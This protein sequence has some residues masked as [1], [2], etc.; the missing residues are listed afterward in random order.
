MLV[1][2][3]PTSRKKIVK[4]RVLSSRVA[5]RGPIFS[6]V[7]E[8]VREPGGYVARRD[9]VRH[10]GSVV[11]LAV[12]STGAVPRVLLERQYRHAAG[13][14][15]WELPAGKIDPGEEALA[16]AKRELREETGYTAARWSLALRFYVSPGF[17]D[18]TMTVFLAREIRQGEATPE[19]DEFI[20]VRLLPLPQAVKM[21][22][23]KTIHDAKTIA[24]ILW[25][26]RKLRA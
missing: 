1:F 12:E 9:I 5:F 20:T 7:T 10:P 25:L 2:P 3:M 26:D 16:A 15:L 11:I 6:V 19:E 23:N 17:L 22:T 4:P 18:E 8:Q 24:S 14:Y 13:G 21:A